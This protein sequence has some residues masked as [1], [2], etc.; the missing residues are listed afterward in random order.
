VADDEEDQMTDAVISFDEPSLNLPVA[1]NC[2]VL[3]TFTEVFEGLTERVTSVDEDGAGALRAA[4]P[5]IIIAKTVED[6]AH[7]TSAFLIR[8]EAN[9]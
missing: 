8:T 6:T 4:V 9:L 7:S 2:S 3:F 1:L 5:Q